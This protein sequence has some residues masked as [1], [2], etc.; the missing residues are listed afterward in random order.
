MFFVL[1]TIYNR[2]AGRVRG[3]ALSGRRQGTAFRMGKVAEKRA[4]TAKATRGSDV[5][6]PGKPLESVSADGTSAVYLWKL[7]P[8]VNATT[9]VDLLQSSNLLEYTLLVSVHDGCGTVVMRSEAAAEDMRS[10]LRMRRRFWRV[11]RSHVQGFLANVSN[12]SPEQLDHPQ[13]NMLC[14]FTPQGVAISPAEL[15]DLARMGMQ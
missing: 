10:M 6:N 13:E 5:S 14:A 4:P 3:S 8:D 11:C 12:L 2:G 15:S 1:L 9:I 7:L